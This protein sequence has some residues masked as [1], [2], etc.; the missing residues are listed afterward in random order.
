MLVVSPLPV[1]EPSGLDYD[2]SLMHSYTYNR[3]QQTEARQL[4]SAG[5][6]SQHVCVT[7]ALD[8]KD[9]FSL[10]PLFRKQENLR[11]SV[12]NFLKSRFK[13]KLILS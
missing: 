4:Q 11:C 12:L 13:L 7:H 9:G 5:H 1:L 3:N 8:R 10:T 6:F 2:F